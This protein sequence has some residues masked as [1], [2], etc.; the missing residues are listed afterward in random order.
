[1]AQAV[2]KTLLEA[3]AQV[4]ASW[5]FYKEEPSPGTQAAYLQASDALREEISSWVDA[6]FKGL[7]HD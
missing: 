1:M 7:S 3:M 5:A 2:P 4:D 6:F